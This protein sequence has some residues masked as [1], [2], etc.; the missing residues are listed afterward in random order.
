MWPINKKN[1]LK[2]KKCSPWHFM[3]EWVF[4]FFSNWISKLYGPKIRLKLDDTCKM[5]CLIWKPVIN[6][7]MLK[8][9]HNTPVS[10]YVDLFHIVYSPVIGHLLVTWWPRCS[11]PWS[12]SPPCCCC[13]SSSSLFSPYL[14][15]SSLGASSILMRLW[16]KGAH[17]ITSLRPCLLSSRWV[18]YLEIKKSPIITVYLIN[19]KAWTNSV[20]RKLQ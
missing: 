20:Y 14:A 12:L 3:E 8:I 1:N 7:C 16:P 19:R 18:F 2:L 13:S 10:P 15:C 11:T 5:L 9:P 6:I 17:L 4:T